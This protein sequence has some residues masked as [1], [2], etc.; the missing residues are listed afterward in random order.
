MGW[1]VCR[2]AVYR[3]DSTEQDCLHLRVSV[4]RLR[5]LHQGF[6]LLPLFLILTRA[7]AVLESDVVLLLTVLVL[8]CNRNVPFQLCQSST[9]PATWRRKPHTDTV[10]ILSSYTGTPH[11]LWGLMPYRSPVVWW[12][13]TCVSVSVCV[14]A[15]NSPTRWGARASGDQRYWQ[16]HSS[17]D[18]GWK[19][20]TQ[21]G[22]LWRE[23]HRR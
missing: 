19:T 23:Y 2:E 16:I 3:G 6:Q 1:N 11:H 18:P 15:A 5:H 9:C 10:P 8:F 20:E 21:P 4:Y 13:L 14:Q 17:E 7:V 12:L 22:Q